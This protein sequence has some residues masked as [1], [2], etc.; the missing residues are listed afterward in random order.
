MCV[1]CYNYFELIIHIIKNNK[2][3]T[4]LSWDV[5]IKNLAYCLIQQTD[6]INQTKQTDKETNGFKILKW[7][8]VNLNDGQQKCEFELRTGNCCQETA[9]YC[10]YHKDKISLFPEKADGIFYTCSKHKEKMIPECKKIEKLD[11]SSSSN[12]KKK[13]ETENK[14][15]AC[16]LCNSNAEYLLS[17]TNYCWCDV[18]YEKKGKSFVK[19]IATKKISVTTCSKQPIQ[20]LAEKLFL[21]LDV[22]FKNLGEISE[23]LIENQPTLKNPKMKTLAS[24]LYSYFI[25]RGI[26]DKNITCSKITEVKF[27][28]PS[29]KLKVNSTNTNSIL[30]SEKEK[31][32]ANVY[33]MTKSLGI[34]YCK[35]LI[36]DD[37]NKILDG[38]K[39][40]DDMCDAFLQGF[41]YLF[42]PIPEFYF[43]KLEKIGFEDVEKKSTKKKQNN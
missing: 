27:V 22:E 5:G 28:S 16:Q 4:I 26:I 35:A 2:M 32:N 36:S 12:K 37:D 15:I 20:E 1:V 6:Q 8:V 11:V 10:V 24:I 38:V 40:K 13:T 17:G 42:T 31:I 25:V 9:K 23:V 39:K 21:K 19:K 41:Q 33:K 34:K 18:H 29:N 14:K 7:G 43:K 3:K 30:K